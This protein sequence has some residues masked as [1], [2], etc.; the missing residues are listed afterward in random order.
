MLS[1]KLYFT[2]VALFISIA[3]AGFL[4]LEPPQPDNVDIEVLVQF[5]TGQAMWAAAIG[6]GIG[7]I[8]GFTAANALLHQPRERASDYDGRVITRGYW[9]GVWAVLVSLVVMIL[10]AVVTSIEPLAPLQKAQLTVLSGRA[11]LVF[12]IGFAV[13]LI[14]YSLVTR[15]RPWGGQYAFFRR[16]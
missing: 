3:V 11:F 7:A 10:A 15:M 9:A 1:R 5:Y 13:A 8:I 14:T 6:F 4:F 12:A 16:G 2:V